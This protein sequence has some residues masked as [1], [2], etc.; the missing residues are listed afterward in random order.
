MEQ[1][2]S[3]SLGHQPLK[4]TAIKGLQIRKENELAKAAGK[5]EDCQKRIAS[6]SSQLKSLADLDEFLPGTESR[7]SGAASADSWD[8]G[9]LKLLH[10]AS[11]PRQYGC[12]A[13]T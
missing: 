6:L 4:S 1:V 9:D 5:L 10:P 12:L 3:R 13:L 7:S 8:D 11:Y 2:P